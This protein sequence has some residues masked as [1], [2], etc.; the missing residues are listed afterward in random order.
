M[1]LNVKSTLLRNAELSFLFKYT[2]KLIKKK[3]NNLDWSSL[4]FMFDHA[5]HFNC[6]SFK[7]NTE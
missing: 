4:I 7:D 3:R 5:R 1:K 6:V 2:V